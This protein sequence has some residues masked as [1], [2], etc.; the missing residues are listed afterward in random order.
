MVETFNQRGTIETMT[1]ESDDVNG[2]LRR[3]WTVIEQRGWSVRSLLVE[4]VEGG[5]ETR[6]QVSPY[7]KHRSVETLRLQIERLY[8][9]RSVRLERRSREKPSRWQ[10]IP[11]AT[12]I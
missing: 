10:E 1:I 3:I 11:H 8:N 6:V 2:T 5:V 7:G 12:V 9:V 4:E